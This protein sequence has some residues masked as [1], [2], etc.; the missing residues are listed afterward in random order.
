[1]NYVY[2]ENKLCYKSLQKGAY[3]GEIEVIK[4]I[5]RKYS[6]QAIV[7]TDLLIM[8]KSLM[9]LIITDFPIVA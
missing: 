8:N 9:V 5:P 2:G 6:I 3:F 1:V 7:D 4:Q